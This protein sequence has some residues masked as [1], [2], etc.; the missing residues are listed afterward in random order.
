MGVNTMLPGEHNMSA[1]TTCQFNL[2]LDP[3]WRATLA[4]RGEL[5]RMPAVYACLLIDVF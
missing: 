5:D 2:T 3:R 4:A 1:Q